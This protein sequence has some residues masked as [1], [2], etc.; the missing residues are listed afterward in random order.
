[1]VGRPGS[2][3]S[4]LESYHPSESFLRCD[5]CGGDGDI[6]VC[7]ICLES[8]QIVDGVELCGCVSQQL[9]KAA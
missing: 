9:P 1:M 6:E 3:E 2:Y 4:K 8:V 5:E 7:V